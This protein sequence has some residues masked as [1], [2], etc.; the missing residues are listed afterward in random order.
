MK[1][2][3][4]VEECRRMLERV[5]RKEFARAELKL[6]DV[7]KSSQFVQAVAKAGSAK[8]AAGGKVNIGPGRTAL[9]LV[10]IALDAHRAA[11]RL[12]GDPEVTVCGDPAFVFGYD[13]QAKAAVASYDIPREDDLLGESILDQPRETMDPSVW[14]TG[15]DGKPV[16]TEEARRKLSAVVAWAKRW[17][18]LREMTTHVT[19]SIASNSYGDSSDVDLHFCSPELDPDDPKQFNKD[20]KAAFE[21]EFG[22]GTGN[23]NG[24]VGV[25]PVEVF[26]QPNPFGDLM[27]VG[28]YD[29]D[30]GVWECGPELKDTAFDPY[31]EY[32]EADMRAVKD[33]AKDVR[34]AIFEAYEQALV[35]QKTTDEEFKARL[36]GRLSRLL[37][38]AKGLYDGIKK[39]RGELSSP[40]SKAEALRRRSS[41]AWHVADSSYKLLDRLGY[42]STLKAMKQLSR[43]G[44]GP[45]EAA[46][47]VVR[48]VQDGV[49]NNKMITDADE[50]CEGLGA[51]LRKAALGGL[52]GLA[53]AG[54]AWGAG[55]KAPAGGAP[56]APAPAAARAEKKYSGLSRSN[57]VNLLA[58][59]AYNEAMTDWMEKRDDDVLTA[60]LNVVQNR[61]GGDPD[62][63]AAEAL[64]P[65]QFVSAARHL[66]GGSTDATYVRWDP[67]T[68]AAKKG[69]RPSPKQ[70]DCWK[71]CVAL[72]GQAVDG[73][74][75]GKIGNRNM[76]ANKDKDDEAS[77][78][79]WGSSCDLR[80]GKSHTYG[81]D[82]RRDPAWRKKQAEEAARK[83]AEAKRLEAAKKKAEAERKKKRARRPPPSRK[84]VV[85]RGDS[86]WSIA[87]ANGR[88]V[89]ELKA[90]NGLTG[91]FLR[92]GMTLKV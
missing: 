19:G 8:P 58:A 1:V 62:K 35:M 28:C 49:M 22:P 72:A 56:R 20:F 77:W 29:W 43:D 39:A 32:Y 5:G 86:L 2:S 11:Q 36:F 45:D 82:K 38:K 57:L 21:A 85:R 51:G 65:S 55:P 69:G 66:K 54:S 27:S 70:L 90:A 16:P 37:R 67:S 14:T 73:T 84:Y 33:T 4:F 46:A 48:A 87:R 64:S 75:P 92:P 41:R 25:H 68:E 76:M 47:A 13:S 30:A 6:H 40:K 44:A 79:A 17:L 26:F 7:G 53:L 42:V 78:N 9:P 31:S 61:A 12:G 91:D 15:A 81:Y 10:Q 18:G 23:E 3:E 52:A 74:L 83:A 88:T 71:R 24:F 60:V 80:V 59:V 34:N 50:L 89:E 63:Y